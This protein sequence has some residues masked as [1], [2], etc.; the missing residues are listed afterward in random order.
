MKNWDGG[1]HSN[2]R[3]ESEESDKNSEK[4]GR[5]NFARNSNFLSTKGERDIG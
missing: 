2:K 4:G 3:C 1:M 5:C